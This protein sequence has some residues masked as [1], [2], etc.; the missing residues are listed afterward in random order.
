MKRSILILLFLVFMISGAFSQK[1][2]KVI[3]GKEKFSVGNVDVMIV[4]IFASDKNYVEKAWKKLLKRYSGKVTTKS[5]IVAT[6]VIIKK[7]GDK[8]FDVYS[9]IKEGKD[10]TTIIE[11]AL[12]LGGAFLSKTQHPQRYKEFKQILH[13]FSVEVSKEA[14]REQI[15]DQE[16]ILSKLE[17]SQEKLEKE[18]E[19][20]KKTIEDCKQKIKESE[21]AIAKNN[22]EQEE[23][24]KEIETQRQV[25]IKLSEKERAI[26]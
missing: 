5:E 9:R 24:K 7:M 14:V 12:D 8:R 25:V 13:D 1:K 19:S 22:K 26:E 18:Q 6:D 3:D 4:N 21:E 11:V 15:D 17:Q 20:L 23:K 16:K 2:V 10:N